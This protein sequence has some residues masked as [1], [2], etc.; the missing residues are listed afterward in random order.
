MS[1]DAL[2]VGINSY[3]AL[4]SLSAPAKDAEAVASCLQIYGEFRVR[5]LPEVI[6]AGK[7]SVGLQTGVTTEELEAALVHLFKPNGK[8]IPHTAVF[9]YSGH[10]LQRHAGVREGYLATSDTNPAQGRYGISLFWLRRLLQESPVRQRVVILDCCHSGEFMSFLEADPGAQDGTDRLFMAASREY[11]AAYEALDNAH[12]VFTAALV[13]GL[14]PNRTDGGIVSNYHLAERVSQRLKGELQQPLFESSGSEIVLTRASGDTTIVQG[15]P[16]SALERLRQL[17][18]AFCPYRGMEP[19]DDIHGDYFFGREDLT[20]QLIDKVY[21]QPFCAVVGASGSGKT[22]LLRAGLIYQLRQRPERTDWK[23]QYVSVDH[24]PLRCLAEAFINPMAD[25][26]ERAEQLRQAERFLC[27][28]QD[29]LTQLIR[30]CLAGS[31]R[32]DR[33]ML[34]IID[35]LEQIFQGPD[36]EDIRHCRDLFIQQLVSASQASE[37]P[38]RIVISLRAD[39]LGHFNDYPD[40]RQLVRRHT[41]AVAPLDYEQMKL[42]ITKPAE[43]VG[44]T[45]DKNLIYSLLLDV[46]G[47]PGELPLLQQTL[48]SLW[49]ARQIDPDDEAPRLT[50]E[51]YAELGGIRHVLTHYATTIYED[52]PVQEQQAAQ[53][54]FLALCELGEGGDDTRRRALTEELINADFSTDLIGRTLEKLV[55]ARLVVVNHAGARQRQHPS[56][57]VHLPQIAW[58]SQNNAGLT[59]GHLWADQAMETPLQLDQTLEIVHESLIRHWPLLQGW[60]QDNRD[61]LRQKRRLDAAA[62]EWRQAGY[63]HHPEY[64]LTRAR[65]QQA[66]QLLQCDR[67]WLSTLAQD[68]VRHSR[69][70]GRYQRVRTALV[71]TMLP[72]AVVGGLSLS[73]TP[74]EDG[75][76]SW[77]PGLFSQA[78]TALAAES[79]AGS[80]TGRSLSRAIVMAQTDLQRRSLLLLLQSRS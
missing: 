33:R 22:S 29:G 75:A 37:A 56:P 15:K 52:L 57:G 9:Y 19:F 18:F 30:A 32:P 61:I 24:E 46:V 4:P 64:L 17:R 54:I 25:G 65:L 1:R 28:G 79:S 63:T 20:Q 21:Q 67:T 7:P 80:L 72:L 5:R 50:L 44:L 36:T 41:L 58:R 68:Y 31:R 2:I 14:N 62:Q 8:N 71:A 76:T 49:K 26:L 38:L 39:A 43:K 23:I 74:R 55:A 40:F 60:L 70:S 27:N 77:I 73:L 6:H 10:G 48:R 34:L 42:A 13:A 51:A 12:S 45:Y 11:E 78:D 66:E 16:T 47:A 53:R 3:Q 35:D 69:R 59:L